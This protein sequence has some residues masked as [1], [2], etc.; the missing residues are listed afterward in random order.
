MVLHRTGKQKSLEIKRKNRTDNTS[1]YRRRDSFFCHPKEQRKVRG[2]RVEQWVKQNLSPEGQRWFA[3]RVAFYRAEISAFNTRERQREKRLEAQRKY[4]EDIDKQ[5]EDERKEE[6]RTRSRQAMRDLE[7]Y[8][9][10]SSS[11]VDKLPL[12]LRTDAPANLDVPLHPAAVAILQKGGLVSALN[13][14][15]SGTDNVR[16]ST[17]QKP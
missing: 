17:W 8:Y 14:L 7:T 15:A 13:V 1:S 11:K 9:R 5:V 3:D 10:E 16:V 2:T 12:F 6:R 4:Q